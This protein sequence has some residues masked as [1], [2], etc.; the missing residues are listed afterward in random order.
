MVG[1]RGRE[2]LWVEKQK[3]LSSHIFRTKTLEESHGPQQAY[4]CRP[5]RACL[6]SCHALGLFVSRAWHL[7][8]GIN[9]SLWH[10]GRGRGRRV[11][12][13]VFSMW[14]RRVFFYHMVSGYW[15]G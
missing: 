7:D 14:E 9:W 11:V 3:Q 6:H 15:E 13:A 4:L 2:L 5:S 12:L 1:D 8:L 10:H